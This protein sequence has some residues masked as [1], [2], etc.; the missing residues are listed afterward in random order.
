M[1]NPRLTALTNELDHIA[2]ELR[3]KTGLDQ[4]RFEREL[5]H[6]VSKHLEN[7]ELNDASEAIQTFIDALLEIEDRAA[8]Y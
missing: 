3:S 8:G 7:A 4:R 1:S 6:L 2:R 5:D